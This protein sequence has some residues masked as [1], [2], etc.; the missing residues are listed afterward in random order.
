MKIFDKLSGKLGLG[1]RDDEERDELDE[2]DDTPALARPTAKSARPSAA[3]APSPAP[4]G[5][6]P[7]PLPTMPPTGN[8]VNMQQAASQLNWNER[9]HAPVQAKMKFMVIEPKQFDDVQQIANCL[10]DRKPVL[11]NFERTEK[12]AIQRILDFVSGTT[13][14]LS[15]DIKKVGH[16]VYLCAPS[17]VNVDVPAEKT[18]PA[19]AQA[20]KA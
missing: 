8:L 10:R 1:N 2:L 20:A 16:K 18:E 14:A 9:V 17:N 13:Y 6:R 3:T 7:Q 15:G 12:E 11:I 19:E 5:I 4:V